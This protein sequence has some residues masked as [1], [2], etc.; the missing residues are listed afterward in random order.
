[1]IYSIDNTK[2]LVYSDAQYYGC[3][4]LVQQPILLG[5][6]LLTYYSFNRSFQPFLKVLVLPAMSSLTA[7]YG[8]VSSPYLTPVVNFI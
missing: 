8:L 5:L 1:M 4:T 6:I 3:V 2:E 7:T